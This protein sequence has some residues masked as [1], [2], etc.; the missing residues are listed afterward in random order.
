MTVGENKENQANEQLPHKPPG[1]FCETCVPV[2]GS[3]LEACCAELSHAAISGS[4]INFASSLSASLCCIRASALRHWCRKPSSAVCRKSW[5]TSFATR[6]PLDGSCLLHT[7]GR[8]TDK[9]SSPTRAVTR[10]Y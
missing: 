4:A 3:L 8:S 7:D 9:L 1:P 2:A 6:P 5:E 10:V